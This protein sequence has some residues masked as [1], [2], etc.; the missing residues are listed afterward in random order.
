MKFKDKQKCE[1]CSKL[2]NN[3]HIYKGKLLCYFCWIKKVIIIR[4]GQ[5]K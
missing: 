3:L 2:Y 1:G 5:Q 4:I